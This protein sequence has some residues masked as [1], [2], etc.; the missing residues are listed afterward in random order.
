MRRGVAALVTAGAVAAGLVSPAAASAAPLP[1]NCTSQFWMVG[2]R[3]AT[4]YICDGSAGSDGSWMRTRAFYAPAYVADGYA[5]CYSSAFCTLTPA[6]S[7]PVMDVRESY[8]VTPETVLPDE[9]GYMGF[10]AIA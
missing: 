8:R 9:P 10:G 6:K 2:L 5:V 3:A 1:P 4:R 7:V